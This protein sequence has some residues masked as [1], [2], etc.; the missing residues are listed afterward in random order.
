MKNEV[1]P[2]IYVT[3]LFIL[4]SQMTTFRNHSPQNRLFDTLAEFIP[5]FKII[6]TTKIG[7]DVRRTN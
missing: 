2:V 4:C 7:I 5:D 6:L 1:K 3:G